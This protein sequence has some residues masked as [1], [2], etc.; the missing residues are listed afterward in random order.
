MH[1]FTIQSILDLINYMDATD[2]RQMDI[3]S[4]VIP[5][6]GKAAVI[7]DAERLLL[8]VGRDAMLSGRRGLAVN[9][10][11]ADEV[12]EYIDN[13]RT[14]LRTILSDGACDTWHASAGCSTTPLPGYAKSSPT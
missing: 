6:P 4:D 8:L 11:T 14:H 1:R 7:S 10:N 9:M 5:S 2:Y 12:A 13:A 3:G